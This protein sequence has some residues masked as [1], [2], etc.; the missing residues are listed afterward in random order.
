MSQ[1]GS[2]GASQRLCGGRQKG[3]VHDMKKA[4]HCLQPR[5]SF[6]LH[7]PAACFGTSCVSLVFS[8]HEKQP[9]HTHNTTLR[10]TSPFS[11]LYV[12]KDLT[13][14]FSSIYCLYYFL[15]LQ[16]SNAVFPQVT[17]IFPAED[18]TAEAWSGNE[19]V[20]A[21]AERFYF[22]LSPWH[23]ATPISHSPVLQ[24]LHL[25]NE[26]NMLSG[27]GKSHVGP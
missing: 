10:Q 8:A 5:F 26:D 2:E 9:T 12:S 17:S 3:V 11:A 4:Y 21:G 22:Q 6:L 7:P 1:Q 20:E 15:E 19:H 23:R 27:S 16:T 25:I 13:F 24:F 18:D 14:F